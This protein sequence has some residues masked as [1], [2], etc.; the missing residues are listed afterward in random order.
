MSDNV[1]L[2]PNKADIPAKPDFI[3]PPDE[4]WLANLPVGTVF[5]TRH[6]Q[7]LP[8]LFPIVYAF[9]VMDHIGKPQTKVTKL[10]TNDGGPNSP[11]GF[12][13][14]DTLEF[15]RSMDLKDTLAKV[16]PPDGQI[17]SISE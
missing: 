4:N 13:W 15:S 12:I 14:V 6:K 7:K 1:L 5:L 3:L 10:F 8:Q 16:L 2:F 11:G 17:D 9:E